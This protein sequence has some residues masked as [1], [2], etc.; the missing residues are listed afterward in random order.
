[1]Y[2]LSGDLVDF[3]FITFVDKRKITLKMNLSINILKLE[4]NHNDA[5]RPNLWLKLHKPQTHLIPMFCQ[6]MMKSVQVVEVV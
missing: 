1:M 2:I 6:Q 3:G 4:E 5:F